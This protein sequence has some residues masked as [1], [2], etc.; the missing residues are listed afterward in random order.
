MNNRFIPLLASLAYLTAG[1]ANRVA[2]VTH[3]SIGLDVSGTAQVPTRVSLS[4][5]RHEA[6]IVP[7]KTNGEAHAV[8]GGLDADMTWFDGQIIRQ[9][10]ATGEAAKL[11]T[12]AGTEPLVP[13]INSDRAPLVFVTA[14]TLGLKLS[15]GEQSLPPSLLLGYRRE[16]AT[17][18]PVPDPSQEV[19]SVYADIEIN[20][21]GKV[22][23]ATTNFS[24]LGGVRIRQS[25]ATGKAAES[26]AK[27]NATVREKL[28]RAAG[29]VSI[30]DFKRKATLENEI[31]EKL[32]TLSPEQQ[33]QF[34]T[35]ADTTFP[36]QSG[37]QLAAKDA[38][39]FQ[40]V[41][42]PGLGLEEVTVV[43]EKIQQIK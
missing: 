3:S 13:T 20:T 28:N 42:L 21:T 5:D 27:G 15:A 33:K 35:W 9:T 34:F 26:L 32:R 24:S 4:F 30:S 12:G 36:K 19:R 43:W 7:R 39:Y 41:F 38:D 18:I 22:A 10:F 17:V 25:F 14:T 40:N 11:A 2:F 37:G 6:A 16:E 31:G 29:A 23:P 8:Y 1:C